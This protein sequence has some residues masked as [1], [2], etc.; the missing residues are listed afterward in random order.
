MKL[1][2]NKTIYTG[3]GKI[4]SGYIRYDSVIAETGSMNTFIPQEDDEEIFTEAGTVIPGFIDVH[5]HGGYGYDSMDASP[6]EIDAMVQR[7]TA[8]EGITSYFCTTMTQSYSQI[9]SAMKNIRTAAERNPVIQGIHVEGPFVS[10]K[11]KG[12]QNEAYIKKPDAE[13]LSRWN[14]LSGGR[15]RVV[16]YAPEEASPEFETWCLANKILPS[17]GHSCAVYDLLRRSKARHVTHLYNAQRGLNH[18]EPGVTGY[19]LLTDGVMVELICDGIHI[20][21]EMIRLAHK[22]KGSRGIEL[23]TDSMRAKGMPDGKSELGG[24]TVYVKDGTARL[25]DGTI[26]GSVLS[27]IQAFR[28]IMRFTGVGIEDAVLMTSVNQAQEFGLTQKGS[29]SV[30]RDADFVLLDDACALKGTVSMGRL[31]LPSNT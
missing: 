27:Y 17:A 25:E 9:E 31:F 4:T 24:Q 29:I 28:N 11:Y 1:L 5:S 21:P 14:D 18:R 26:A 30:G 12:A 13:V 15:I 8:E 23:I 10:V 6:E 19:G 22:V 2:K 7:M 3:D 20:R 16:T